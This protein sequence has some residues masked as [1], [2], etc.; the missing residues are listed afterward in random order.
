MGEGSSI[1]NSD[2]CPESFGIFVGASAAMRSVYSYIEQTAR[3]NDSILLVGEKGVGKQT[4]AQAIHSAMGYDLKSFK[5][6]QP[7]E[8]SR[9]VNS[10]FKN[11][12]FFVSLKGKPC[13]NTLKSLNSQ[14][15]KI[16]FFCEYLSPELKNIFCNRY[17]IIPP[18]RERKEDIIDIMSFYIN[19][20]CKKEE[21]DALI[22]TES[23][24][25]ALFQYC[26]PGNIHEIK[27]LSMELAKSI[28]TNII[29]GNMLPKRIY[30]AIR[31]TNLKFN[32]DMF[33]PL[34]EIEKR[35]IKQILQ[36][37]NG[38][39]C[40]TAKSLGISRSTIYRKIQSWDNAE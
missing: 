34:S 38:D 32:H 40:R 1:L 25:A 23:A 14:E 17:L 13:L 24:K 16:I 26:W 19:L 3:T 33:I 6:T 28:Q 8:L 15:N 36:I 11:Q 29:E 27:C 4:C 31:Q 2:T 30:E 21:R 37:H 5:Q 35:A 9:M 20:F 7:T 22:L 10:G 39:I 18:V 12:T